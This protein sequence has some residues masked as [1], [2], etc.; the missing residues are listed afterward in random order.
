MIS[1]VTVLWLRRPMARN[2]SCMAGAWPSISG[3]ATWPL[4]AHFFALAFFHRAADQFHRLGH[5]EGLGQVF[6][7]AALERRH[8]AV[9]VGVGGH[10]DHRQ[11]RQPRLDLVQQVE[12]RATGHAD[13]ADQDLGPSLRRPAPS[14][15]RVR[16]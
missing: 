16:W 12:A 10:D 5:V 2:T 14:A 8:R 9:E 3:V 6:E 15:P 4:V 13:V 11:A 7:G 1:T